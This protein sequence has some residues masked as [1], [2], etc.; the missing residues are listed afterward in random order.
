MCKVV[1]FKDAILHF[2]PIGDIS[3]AVY[4]DILKSRISRKPLLRP[5]MI[6]IGGLAP[7]LPR[8]PSQPVDEDE[9]YQGLRG[10]MQEI[11]SEGPFEVSA[12]L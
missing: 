8:P 4:T 10:R 1:N 6:W 3:K 12:R 2:A 11:E 9:V 7:S 5:I